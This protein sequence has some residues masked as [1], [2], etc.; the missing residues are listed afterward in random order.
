[1]TGGTIGHL[2]N[3]FR[4]CPICKSNSTEKGSLPKLYLFAI[5]D[6]IKDEKFKFDID[7]E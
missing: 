2:I 3:D 7:N 1:M 4:K 6:I 5:R